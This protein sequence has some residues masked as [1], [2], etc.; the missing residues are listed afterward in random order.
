[1]G[2]ERDARPEDVELPLLDVVE[3]PCVDPPHRLG[4]GERGARG[5][6][7]STPEAEGAVPEG[8]TVFDGGGPGGANLDPALVGA[9]RPAAADAAGGGIGFPVGSGWG[10]PVSG[11][12]SSPS[13]SSWSTSRPD[14]CM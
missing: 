9:L 10:S 8:T 4:G 13:P 2:R 3:E 14:T 7:G 6:H 12:P 5:G 1:M 11:R